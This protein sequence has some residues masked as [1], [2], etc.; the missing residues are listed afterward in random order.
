[1]EN[2]KQLVDVNEKFVINACDLSGHI[3]RFENGYATVFDRWANVI[4]KFSLVHAPT[5]DAVEVVRCKNCEHSKTWGNNGTLLCYR[6]ETTI[7]IVKPDAYCDGSQRRYAA[8][9]PEV[10]EFEPVV[11]GNWIGGYNGTSHT[12]P[13]CS[14]CGYGH[15][16]VGT[17]SYCPACGAKMDGGK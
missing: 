17:A 8:D 16:A 1:M 3:I 2:K 5:V 7:H 12:V 6:D 10:L 9:D 4:C 11:H 15:G 13:K 14:R